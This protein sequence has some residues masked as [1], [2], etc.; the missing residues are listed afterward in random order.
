[1]NQTL[2]MIV[3]DSVV[4]REMLNYIIDSDPRLKVVS[5]V[6]SG[7]A[8]LRELD[9]TSPHVISLDIRLPGMDGFETTQQIMM[10]RPTPIVVISQ[11]VDDHALNISMNA[12]RAGALAV[13]EK[14]PGLGHADYALI[15]RRICDQLVAMSTV[16]VVRQRIARDLNIGSASGAGSASS[17]SVKGVELT[18]WVPGGQRPVDILGLVASTGGPNALLHVLQALPKNFPAPIAIVQ[19]ITDS[20][21]ESFANWLGVET[22]FKAVLVKDGEA[23][24]PGRIHLAPAGHHLVASRGIFRLTRDEPVSLQRPS[25]TTLFRSM[26]RAYGERSLGVLLTGMGDDGA[27]GL[28]E[29]RRA[30]AHTIAEHQS[31]A[32]VYGMPGAAERLGA[33]NEILPLDQIGPR[34]CEVFMSAEW[35]QRYAK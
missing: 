2:V 8:A 21:T 3:E 30:G 32:V 7:E 11:D 13:M 24:K 10:R 15:A 16:K 31:T 6:A 14:P 20:F 35:S 27:D 34:V 22:P 28:L 17:T 19:H 4:V 26:A 33:A 29:M 9:R 23:A 18:S 5:A 25:G 1:M 12:L